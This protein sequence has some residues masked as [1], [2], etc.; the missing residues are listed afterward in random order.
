MK[1]FIYFLCL[2]SAINLICGITTLS[3]T[4]SDRA[5]KIIVMPDHLDWNYKCGERPIFKV[6][7]LKH[8]SPMQNVKIRY[9]L[10]EDLMKPH[11]VE[12]LV[13]DNGAGEI[14]LGTMKS[15]GFLRCF[16][17]VE[18]G[19][20]TYTGVATAG[21]EPDKI[22]PTTEMPADFDEFWQKAL[23]ES[24]NIALEPVITPVPELCTAQYN[25]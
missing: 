17:Y 3:A 11:K 22:Q 4:P 21:F 12:N 8:H 6:L 15:P 10:S 7:V 16:V 20:Y 25:T 5:V 2:A 1:K 14:K 23:Q 18:D 24:A 13:L 9:E 19:E